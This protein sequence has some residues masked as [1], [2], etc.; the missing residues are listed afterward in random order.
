LHVAH[1]IS[2]GDKFTLLY[3][4]AHGLISG[5]PLIHLS[6]SFA[7]KFCAA[8]YYDNFARLNQEYAHKAFVSDLPGSNPDRFS[9]LFW[10]GKIV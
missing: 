1:C 10:I 8:D 5:L 4:I 3:Y 9:S 2:G 6:N 7:F